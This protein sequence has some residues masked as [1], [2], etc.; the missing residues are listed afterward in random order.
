MASQYPSTPE[1]YQ[2]TRSSVLK[3]FIHKR[4]PSAGDALPPPTDVFIAMP[5]YD[6]GPT[7]PFVPQE[8]PHNSRALGERQENRQSQPPPSPAKR[9]KEGKRPRTSGEGGLHYKSLHKKTLSSISLKSLAGKDGASK[10]PKT[11]DA[12]SMRAKKTKSASNFATLLSRPKSSKSLQKQ[13]MEDEA[14]AAKDKENR[15]PQRSPIISSPVTAFRPPIYAQFSSE[16]FTKQPLGGKFLEDEIDL[17]T[18]ENYSPGKQRNFYNVQ[19]SQPSLTQREGAPRPKSTYLPSNYSVQDI[20]RQPSRESE[21]RSVELDRRDVS[22]EKRPS[23]ERRTTEPSNSSDRAAPSRGQRVLAAVSSFGSGS[24]KKDDSDPLLEDKDIDRE[25]EAMLDRRNIPENMRGKM[26]SLTIKMKRDFVKQDWAETAAAKNGRP[27]TNGSNSSAEPTTDT[28]EVEV[29][30]KRPRS[31][32]FTLSR[33]S[34]K[35]SSSGPKSKKPE[36]SF[37]RHSRMKSSD[38]TKVDSKALTTAGA[39][40]QTLIAKA[41]GQTP[42]DFV[43][44]LRKTRQPE[45]VE[46]GRLHKLRLLLRNETVAWTDDFVGQGGMAEMVGLLHR[47]MEVEWREEHEDALLHEVLLCLKALS[48]TAL[49]LEYLD[50]IQST[51]F[52]ALLHMIFDEEKKGPSEFTTRNIITS[53]LFTYLKSAPLAL[54]T[55]RAKTIL[56]YLRNQA[57][58]ESQRPVDFVM[59]MRRPRPYTVWNKEVSNVTKEVFWIFLHNLNVVSLPRVSKDNIHD[60]SST[61]IASSGPNGLDLTNPYHV[62]MAKHFPPELPPVPAAPYVGGVE[63]E[64]TNYLA[65]HLDLVNGIMACLPTQA[66]RNDLREQ[67]RV[68]GWEKCMGGTLRLCKEKFYGGV[69]AGLRCWVAAAAEDGWNTREVRCGPSTEGSSPKKSPKKAV[70]VQEAPKIQMKLSFGGDGQTREISNAGGGWL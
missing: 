38:S 5:A 58:S 64:A 69:H 14:R 46:V 13:A 62:Y 7:L 16:H 12:A 4:S 59:D 31:R 8:N 10:P 25:F 23:C 11:K 36:E 41:K 43:T 15:S 52:P 32:T 55:L 33:A 1:T 27:G 70:P 6:C 26:R 22:G 20:S 48:T 45:K 53:L 42:E 35:E 57:P 29:K 21:R 66:E 50:D 24:S 47:T 65:S 19:G 30:S 9:S 51:L 34:S 54:R 63:W 40:A 60:T 17:Y 39:V 49:A 2:R 3:S 56:S 18:P 61:S 44:Y 67:M 68:S 37:K 28:H